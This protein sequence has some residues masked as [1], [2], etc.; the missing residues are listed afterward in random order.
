M[1][2]KQTIGCL[3]IERILIAEG[4]LEIESLMSLTG[5]DRA[6]AQAIIDQYEFEQEMNRKEL[7]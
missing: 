2:A 7:A 5:C 3:V 6:T 1:S 4:F